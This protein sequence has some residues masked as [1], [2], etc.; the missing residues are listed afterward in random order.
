MLL[1][2]NTVPAC[3]WTHSELPKFSELKTCG[4]GQTSNLNGQMSQTL[5]KALVNLVNHSTCSKYFPVR[6]HLSRGLTESH[7][8]AMDN[9]RRTDTCQVISFMFNHTYII[10]LFKPFLHIG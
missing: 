10:C 7:I 1:S 9:T 5:N 4:F 6:Q 8:C 3:L 2:K